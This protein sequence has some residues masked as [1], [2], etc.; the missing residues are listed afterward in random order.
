MKRLHIVTLG[1][2][3]MMTF[4]ML[5]AERAHAVSLSGCVDM[6]GLPC[7]ANSGDVLAG[8]VIVPMNGND[9]ENIVEA[10]LQSATGMM[11]DLTLLGKSDGGYGTYNMGMPADPSTTQSGTWM[12]PDTV[13]YYTVKAANSFNLFST[14]GGATSGSYSTMSILNNGGNQPMVSHISFWSVKSTPPGTTP[15]PEPSTMMLLGS[16]LAGLAYWR[17]KKG[18]QS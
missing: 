5:T 16:G 7:T 15:T 18:T 4:G 11:V 13:A 9:K 8:G 6:A 3:A 2:T 1:L 10:A 12:T 14:G 17:R